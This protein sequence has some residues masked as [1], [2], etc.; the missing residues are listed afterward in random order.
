MGQFG[1]ENL[2]KGLEYKREKIILIINKRVGK[3][4]K[5]EVKKNKGSGL[6][7]GVE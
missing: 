7:K 5:A 1:E 2:K 3:S 4:F 6:R